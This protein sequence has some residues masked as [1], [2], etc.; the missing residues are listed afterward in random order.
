MSQ[1]SERLRVIKESVGF[2]RLQGSVEVN[3]VYAHYQHEGLD[4]HHPDGGEAL[5]LLTPLMLKGPSDYM[6]RLA[7]RAITADGSDVQGAMTDNMEDLSGEVYLRAPWEFGDL[8]ASGHPV[9]S[10]NG[11]T[12]YDRPPNV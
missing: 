1:F 2:G 10:V 4:F 3:Q 8:R 9:V 5:Y 12:V 11:E 6:V 7:D